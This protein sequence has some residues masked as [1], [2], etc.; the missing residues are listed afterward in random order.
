MRILSVTAQKPHATGSG[1]YLCEVVGALA[2]LGHCQSVIAGVYGEDQV[3]LPPGVAFYPVYFNT[4]A[5][6]FPIVGMSDEMPYP[7]TRYR[8]MDGAMTA[9]FKAAFTQALQE[10]CLLYTSR[11]V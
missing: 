4:P 8:E 7:S 5:L 9:Q 1:F 3:T 10:A 6:P 11:C 2:G